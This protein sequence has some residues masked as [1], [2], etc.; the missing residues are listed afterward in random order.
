VDVGGFNATID[1]IPGAGNALH[2]SLDVFKRTVKKLRKFPFIVCL[3]KVDLLKEKLEDGVS[4][5]DY[6]PDFTDEP[7]YRNAATFFMGLFKHAWVDI[8][9][10]SDGFHPI[11]TSAISDQNMRKVF[12]KI[13]T[14]ALSRS[15]SKAGL[16]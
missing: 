8:R 11:T 14:I 1:N 15:M 6:F 10:D 2:D 3:N 13:K 16:Y 5:K 7:K 9:K 12:D 4:L